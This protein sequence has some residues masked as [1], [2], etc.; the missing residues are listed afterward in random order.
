MITTAQMN[1]S[2]TDT[3]TTAIHPVRILMA[4]GGTGGHVFPAISIADALKR[5]IISV[6]ILF[7]G[8]RDRMEWDTVPKYGYEIKSIWISG[9]HRR[10][11]LK[12]LLFPVKVIV[13]LIQSFLIL[14]SFKPVVVVSCGG[15]ASG[16]VGWMASMLGIQ[17]VIQE[18]NSYPGITNRI[19]AKKADRIFTAFEDVANF[20]PNE[21]ITLTGNPVRGSISKADPVQSLKIFGFSSDKKILLVLGGSGG[22]KAINDIMTNNIDQLHNE[23]NLQI[24]WQ[25]GRN[26]YDDLLKKI[27]PDQYAH[28]RLIPYIDDMP[29]AYSVADLVVSRAGAG[30]CSELMN[31]GQPALLIPSPNVAGDHQVKNAR[32]MAKSSAATV[33]N[34]SELDESF[35]QT[36]VGFI[37]DRDKLN[38]MRQAMLKIAK[39][40]A[41]K[42]IS[43]EIKTLVRNSEV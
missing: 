6:E 42:T 3:L 41:A 14:K 36:V 26:Y 15:F 38:Q 21:K 31:I 20:L 19:L 12:N 23:H 39:P 17:L 33:L 22:A 4:A 11:T 7:V 10:F 43:K 35:L 9:L 24:I 25:C 13:S 29:A 40:D 2:S 27:H 30:T 8:T 1:I 28:L 32:S 34:E 16:P 18:Q 37:H 5:E